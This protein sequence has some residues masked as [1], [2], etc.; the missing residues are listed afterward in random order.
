[1]VWDTLL[2]VSLLEQELEHID[3]VGPANL[4]PI[5]KANEIRCFLKA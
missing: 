1:M 2:C 5:V 4:N 3:P